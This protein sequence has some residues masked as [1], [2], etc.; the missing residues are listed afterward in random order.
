LR[1]LPESRLAGEKTADF[2]LLVEDNRCGV[3]E[4]KRLIRTPRTPENGWEVVERDGIRSATRKDDN[5]PQ[6]VTKIIQE[7]WLQLASYPEAKILTIVNDES[8]ADA[9]DLGEAFNGFMEYGNSEGIGYTNTASARLANGR[10]R[11][12]KWN[13]DLYIWIDRVRQ[14]APVFKVVTEEGHRIARLHFGCPD[15]GAPPNKALHL[16]AL[17][18]R[19]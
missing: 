16:S 3:M 19:R 11:E 15:L 18:H 12:L 7:A 2:E 1:K 9:D 17:A 10:I 14:S 6:R 4:V 13:I 5:S 8:L